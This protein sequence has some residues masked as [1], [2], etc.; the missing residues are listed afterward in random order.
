VISTDQ[1]VRML[2]CATLVDSS[3]PRLRRLES[4]LTRKFPFTRVG[5]REDHFSAVENVSLDPCAVLERAMH[6]LVLA[7]GAAILNAR[8]PFARR[9]VNGER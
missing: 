2:D 6:R 5:D 8:T 7:E 1:L 3:E 4:D 9:V